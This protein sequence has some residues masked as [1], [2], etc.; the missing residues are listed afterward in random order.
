MKDAKPHHG[1]R[2][3]RLCGDSEYERF[4]VS[5]NMKCNKVMEMANG[6]IDREQSIP[7]LVLLTFIR[8]K[9]SASKFS[10]L[11]KHSSDIQIGG[12]NSHALEAR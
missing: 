4:V 8:A 6:E 7:F 2:L 11:F 1:D 3:V 9:R 5:A 10:V 12:V